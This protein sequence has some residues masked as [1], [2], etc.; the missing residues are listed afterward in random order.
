MCKDFEWKEK[1][2]REGKEL[3]KNIVLIKGYMIIFIWIFSL[4]LKKKNFLCS[5]Y[6]MKYNYIDRLEFFNV[7]LWWLICLRNFWN[8]DVMWFIKNVEIIEVNKIFVILM[9]FK[10]CVKFKVIFCFLVLM[11]IN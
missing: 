7:V 2:N 9:Y 3:V 10:N 11:V 6:E 8:E 5:L 1:I 4:F